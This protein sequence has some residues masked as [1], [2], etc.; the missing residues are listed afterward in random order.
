MLTQNASYPGKA[1]FVVRQCFH[2]G[3]RRLI[4]RGA[5][6]D[7]ASVILCGNPASMFPGLNFLGGRLERHGGE[8]MLVWATRHEEE[9]DEEEA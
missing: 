8:R 6:E 1:D 7:G 5:F 9:S 4:L 2:R 3:T